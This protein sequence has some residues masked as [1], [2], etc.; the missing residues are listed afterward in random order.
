M[1]KVYFPMHM[2]FPRIPAPS[3]IARQVFPYID[4]GNVPHSRISIGC[5]AKEDRGKVH[6]DGKKG[7]FTPTQPASMPHLSQHTK[8]LNPAKTGSNFC[9]A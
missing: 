7:H 9:F 4:Y 2:H 1:N 3:G 6:I 5:P 8:K